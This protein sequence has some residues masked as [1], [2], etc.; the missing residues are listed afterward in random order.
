ML[1]VRPHKAKLDKSPR[2]QER[3]VEVPIQMV[4]VVR[5]RNQYYS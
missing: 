5:T 1:E 2:D 3:L 4:Y